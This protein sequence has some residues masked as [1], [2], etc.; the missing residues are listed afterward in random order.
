MKLSL[1]QT[2]K[3]V[4]LIAIVLALNLAL[5]I[6]VFHVVRVAGTS[7][8]P[9]LNSGELAIVTRFDYR[10]G[11]PKRGD[12]VECRFPQRDA[13][14]LKR[15]IGLPGETVEIRDSQVYID[16]DPLSEPYATGESD[17]YRV[18]LGPNE[19][20][21]LG[22]NRAESYDSRAPEIGSLHKKDFLGRARLVLWPFRI[23]E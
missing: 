14:Y 3:L 13:T 21:V 15:L 10:L 6:Y 7:M 20:L 12:I 11:R 22:D 1:R 18:E 5:R 2:L 8:E 17:D 4:L 19:Y 16:G 9:T 23:I